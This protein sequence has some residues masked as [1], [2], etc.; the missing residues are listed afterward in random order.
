MKKA[1]DAHAGKTLRTV[2][3]EDLGYVRGGNDPDSPERLEMASE[4]PADEARHPV[5]RMHWIHP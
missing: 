5:E 1:D 2:S 3:L 4:P